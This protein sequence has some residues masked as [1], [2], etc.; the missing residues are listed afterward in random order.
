MVAS[1]QHV[2]LSCGSQQTARAV[3]LQHA[4]RVGSSAVRSF[5]TVGGSD[6]AMPLCVSA[7]ASA[8]NLGECSAVLR[9][10]G[11]AAAVPVVV[12]IKERAT[13]QFDCHGLLEQRGGRVFGETNDDPAGF[14]LYL[15]GR[16][17]SARYRSSC[18]ASSPGLRLQAPGVI[19]ARACGRG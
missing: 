17:P 7:C 4:A 3:E 19:A 2:P 18:A 9:G 10:H 1:P 11:E 8:S 12:E 15:G 5:P 6:S 13:A 14:V 16:P